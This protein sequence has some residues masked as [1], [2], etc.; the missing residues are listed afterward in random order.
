[1]FIVAGI[2][3]I[4]MGLFE[5]YGNTVVTWGLFHDV[6]IMTK[7]PKDVEMILSSNKTLTK[8]EEYSF[9][10]PWLGTG[11][12]VSDKKKWQSRRKI[13]T[14]TFHFNILEQ[15]MAVFNKQSDMLVK[16]LKGHDNRKDFNVYDY[17]T[18]C[19]LDIICETSMGIEI[20]AQNNPNTEYVEA[21][22]EYAYQDYLII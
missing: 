4:L 2:F 16:K 7:E 9:M 19:T 17:V 6:N 14:P 21:V 13:I 12:L 22:K 3:K 18:L 15:F 8:S 20:D 11:L 1:M 10:V 5:P